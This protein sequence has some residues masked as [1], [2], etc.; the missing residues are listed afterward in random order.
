MS[1][2]IKAIDKTTVHRICSGQVVLSLAIAVKELVENAIDAGATCVEVKLKEY[3]SEMIEVCDNGA[4][5]HPDN[6]E[7]LTLKYHT[8]KLREFSDLVGVETF[9]FRGEALSSLCA[10]SNVSISTKHSSQDCGANLT[11][12]HNGHIVK[13]LPL[14]RQVG[15]SVSLANIF[16]T[17]P[18]RLKEFQ[19]NIK[20]EFNKMLQILYAYCLVS[21]GIRITCVN[22]TKKGGRSIVLATQGNITVK[23]N[24][25]CV[26]GSKQLT[27]L[28]EL[29]KTLPSPETMEELNIGVEECSIFE[30][31]GL[32]SSCSHGSGRSAPDRQYYFINSRPCD[33]S[34]VSK[35]VN[36]VYHKYNVHQYPFIFMNIKVTKESV[37]VNVTPDKRQIFINQE[38]ALVAIVK[39]TIENA[40]KPIASSFSLNNVPKKPLVSLA[41]SQSNS[42]PNLSVFSQW[43]SKN[44]SNKRSVEE[45]KGETPSKK[46]IKL[47][48]ESEVQLEQKPI[49][50]F[51]E[52]LVSPKE[53]KIHENVTPQDG[54]KK[55]SSI[56]DISDS[57]GDEMQLVEAVEICE[58]QL[59][60]ISSLGDKEVSE[61]PTIS[62]L[63]S[64]T[65]DPPQD[66]AVPVTT[67]NSNSNV[68]V[69][70]LAKIQSNAILSNKS[71]LPSKRQLVDDLIDHSQIH[72]ESETNEKPVPEFQSPNTEANSQSSS[73]SVTYDSYV[74]RGR[75]YVVVPTDIAQVEALC[76]KR[77]RRDNTLDQVKF[78]TT[79]D[80]TKND[81]AEDEL[82]R[83]IT[84]DTFEKM[85]IIGQFN[86]G[87]IVAKLDKDLFIIDQHAS[88]EKYNFETLQKTT[89]ITN[90]KLV[91]PQ[92]LELTA[93]NECILMDNLDVF[94]KN[95]FEFLID[96]EAPATKKVS[97]TAVPL[98]ANRVFGKAD[99]DELL[100]MLQDANDQHI[101]CRPSG[102]RA[103]FASRAC[104]KSVMIGTALNHKEMKRLVTQMG[105]IDHPWNC[106][107]GRPTMRHLVNMEL[108]KKVE[109]CTAV[110]D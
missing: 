7:G 39:A 6:F 28:V 31:E 22:Q 94:K 98:S 57:I 110:D 10:L 62:S 61:E 13:T 97:M 20:K 93:A 47:E 29:Q 23:E 104:R 72:Q 69:S 26:F 56:F 63:C 85:E 88:D 8:S 38:K 106:P 101:T 40:F 109:E 100:F 77:A 44:D 2:S 55:S 12:D 50:R 89:V 73:K 1:G 82:R 15:T 11:F 25:S 36:D 71:P 54:L 74:E 68:P 17:L 64:A 33:P 96:P 91:V 105:T 80:P 49:T 78:R 16:C 32:I 37:D 81:Q 90:Q 42:K 51:I 18:V 34:K 87:F 84:K 76:A 53:P 60:T 99:V 95:G 83:E 70:P 45:D 107:H 24:I 14:A 52:V 41:S 48:K 19:R 43:R 46:V 102:V 92:P 66:A 79:I 65:P 108:V 5:V 103:M 75:M 58:K 86:L 21:T 27:G 67:A 9:G 59:N 4:G 30:L 35:A 3:G